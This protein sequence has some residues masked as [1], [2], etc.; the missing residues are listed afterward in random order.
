MHRPY[1][2]MTI[3]E[4]EV[5]YDARA[6]VADFDAEMRNYR[7]LSDEAYADLTVIRDIAYGAN[8][9][10]RIDLFPAKNAKCPLLVFIHGGYWRALGRPT[11]AFMAKQ[12]V[13]H[14]VAVAVVEYT[15]APAA[16]LDDIVD[17]TRRAVSHLIENSESLPYDADSIHLAGSSAGAHL[18]AMAFRPEIKGALLASGLY[19]LEPLR[20]CKPNEWLS[21]TETSARANSPI[22]QP[23]PND[24][25]TI[26]TW[27]ET[28]TD[29]F[30]RQSRAY[31][32]KVAQADGPTIEF[33][34]PGRNHF[35]VITDL[36]DPKSRLFRATIDMIRTSQKSR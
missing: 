16:T 19:D 36:A 29:E 10:E 12:F 22:Y 35:N 20:F 23:T 6:T 28:E 3:A 11:S 17:Q 32:E 25:P 4:L 5:Q 18:A 21:L 27:G 9:D 14:D 15:L 34:V 2:N 7:S 13:S 26:I 1:R 8:P 24:T 33:E 30:K 31:A